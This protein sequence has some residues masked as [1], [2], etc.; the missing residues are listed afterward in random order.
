MLAN[1]KIIS[2]VF[3]YSANDH[4]AP[5]RLSDRLRRRSGREASVCTCVKQTATFKH[6]PFAVVRDAPTLHSGALCCQLL[7]SK[8]TGTAIWWSLCRTHTWAL[9]EGR[10]QNMSCIQA[11]VPHLDLQE[12]T[13]NVKYFTQI[14]LGA[15]PR[16][17]NVLDIVL[18][19][20]MTVFLNITVLQ[21]I[22]NQFF[23]TFHDISATNLPIWLIFK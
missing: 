20:N 6:R 4:Y 17:I 7:H 16:Y 18:P 2:C 8:W 11:L 5:P 13:A 23:L 15:G 3:I 9:L 19:K 21:I 1:I 14:Q 12:V 22:I 10:H